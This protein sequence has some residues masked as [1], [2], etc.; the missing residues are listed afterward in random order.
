MAEVKLETEERRMVR[1]FT[2]AQ[3]LEGVASNVNESK[4]LLRSLYTQ[5]YL[6]KMLSKPSRYVTG[7]RG[8]QRQI[9]SEK[10]RTN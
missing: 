8:R 6:E 10:K 5:T 4:Q 9:S 1:H 7:R 2:F 3:G